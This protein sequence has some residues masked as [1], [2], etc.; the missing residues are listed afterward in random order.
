M[1]DRIEKQI[2]LRAPI[3]RVWRAVSDSKEFGTWFGA[4]LPER[5]FVAGAH[6]RATITSK[7]YEH[8]TLDIRIERMEPPHLLEYRWHPNAIDPSVDYEQEPT[9]LV[10]FRLEEIEEGTCLTITESGFDALPEHRR[11][12]AF[13]GNESGWASQLRNVERH[14]ANTP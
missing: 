5:Q 2:V 9:T 3:A 14:V 11:A 7:G 6:V 8:V 10:T 4:A 1:T 13:R 12:D